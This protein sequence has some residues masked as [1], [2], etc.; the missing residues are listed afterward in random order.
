MGKKPSVEYPRVLDACCG[1]RMFWFDRANPVAVFMDVRSEVV[2]CDRGPG[3]VGRS[4]VSVSPDVVAD[5]T[6]MPFPDESFDLVVFDPPH[7]RGTEAR[8]KGIIGGKYGVLFPGWEQMLT[9]GFSECFRVLREGGTLIF[10]W[11]EVEIPLSKVLS[12]TDQSPLF[13]HRSG[14]RAETHWVTFYKQRT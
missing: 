1:G 3:S 10:K 8:A 5:F 6:C 2:K 12:L 9:D 11:C 14:R 13:G 4:D 7:I